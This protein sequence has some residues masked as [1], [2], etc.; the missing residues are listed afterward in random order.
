MIQGL[1]PFSNICQF[2]IFF[3]HAS[4]F[5]AFITFIR[6]QY[7]GLKKREEK[8][9]PIIDELILKYLLEETDKYSLQDINDD[10]TNSIGVLNDEKL[11]FITDQLIKY[12]DNFDVSIN[13]QYYKIIN[14]LRIESHIE[15]KFNFTS[16]FSKMKGIQELSSLAITAAESNIFPF[17]YSPNSNI[18]KEARTSYIRLSKNDPFKFLMK[19]MNSLTLGIKLNWW[20][21]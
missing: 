13:D 6:Y 17:T 12:K 9:V 21:I 10:F 18:R 19:P 16:N 15:K 1:N 2:W 3:Y 11:G 14:A 7:K 4:F 20:N 5:F 8:V